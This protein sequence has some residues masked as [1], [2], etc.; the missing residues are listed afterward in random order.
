MEKIISFNT[1]LFIEDIITKYGLENFL[2]E[3]DP[4]FA[5]YFS[6]SQSAAERITA[7]LMFNKAV[8]EYLERNI[9]LAEILPSEKLVVIVEDLIN[10]EIEYNDLP[11]LIKEELGVSEEIAMQIAQEIA[12]NQKI[13]NDR[14]S[15]FIEEDF[16]E[17]TPEDELPNMPVPEKK[18]GLSQ[19][20]Q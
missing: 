12:N 10:Q 16:E 3:S 4:E 6:D 15:E 7:K 20:L 14:V 17:E 9:P 2:V 1:R 5:S 11:I 19:E 13:A 18:G 8:Q